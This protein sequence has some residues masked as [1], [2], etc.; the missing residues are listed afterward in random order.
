MTTVKW[1]GSALFWFMTV[2]IGGFGLVVLFCI[3]VILH[4]YDQDVGPESLSPSYSPPATEGHLPTIRDRG[5][6]TVPSSTVRRRGRGTR[7]PKKARP[8]R[9][10]GRPC[11][12]RPRT[13]QCE[14]ADCYY[15]PGFGP[16]RGISFGND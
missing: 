12:N 11:Y 15:D 14:G 3:W 16:C 8:A 13:V 6:S 2:V 5:R 9:R 7:A 10:V 4:G 1:A